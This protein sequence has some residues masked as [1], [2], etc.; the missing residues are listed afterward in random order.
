MFIYIEEDK[1]FSSCLF[2]HR[3]NMDIYN[4]RKNIGGVPVISFSWAVFSLVH[5]SSE[6]TGTC[7]RYLYIYT[8]FFV[9]CILL[10]K[11]L[12]LVI[13]ACFFLFRVVYC[14]FPTPFY[15]KLNQLQ[16]DTS[17]Y[18]FCGKVIDHII[19][20]EKLLNQTGFTINYLKRSPHSVIDI[21]WYMR[22][23]L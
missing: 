20:C 9:Y 12:W 4:N 5:W 14:M 10:I 6:S 21:V 19:I 23:K 7:I 18:L 16:D 8:H 3:I 22:E 15:I 13:R 1:G 17:L 11:H 2:L